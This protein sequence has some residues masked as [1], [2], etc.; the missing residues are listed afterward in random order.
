MH[1]FPTRFKPCQVDVSQLW[2]QL[3]KVMSQVIYLLIKEITC[4]SKV[5]GVYIGGN[6]GFLAKQISGIPRSYLAGVLTTLK[7]CRL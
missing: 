3:Q 6:V 1:S 7:R 2:R 5:L 4:I